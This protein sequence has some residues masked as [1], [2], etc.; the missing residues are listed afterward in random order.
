MPVTRLLVLLAVASVASACG[1]SSPRTGSDDG[2]GDTDAVILN[3]IEGLDG[4][5][6]AAGTVNNTS[7]DMN[8]GLLQTGAQ[9]RAFVTFDISASI[10][11]SSQ[12]I[13]STLTSMIIL[14][15]LLVRAE[16][17]L[18]ASHTVSGELTFSNS[19]SRSTRIGFTVR[20]EVQG[21]N[22]E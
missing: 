21:S 13:P 20:E 14:P 19:P 1:G 8:I 10:F 5:I 3:S 17:A 18:R 6:K 22:R 7:E 9:C 16:A 2:G 4:E 15:C 12:T 11:R